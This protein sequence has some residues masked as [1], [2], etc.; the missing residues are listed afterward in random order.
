MLVS[1][2]CCNEENCDNEVMT[3]QTGTTHSKHD[4]DN[5]CNNCSPFFACGSCPGFIFDFAGFF[6]Q[7][8]PIAK[9]KQNIP[10]NPDWQNKYFNDFWQPP[11][12]S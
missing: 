8:S 7:P 1:L 2:P 11:K 9:E 4:N 5:P 12:I 10:Y 3:E 6:T